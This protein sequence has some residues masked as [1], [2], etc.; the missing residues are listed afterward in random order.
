MIIVFYLFQL[1]VLNYLK[2]TISFICYSSTATLLFFKSLREGRPA[3]SKLIPG[4]LLLPFTKNHLSFHT[5]KCD[6]L[7]IKISSVLTNSKM[8]KNSHRWFKPS[9]S[10]SK[11]TKNHPCQRKHYR[12][13][14]LSVILLTELKLMN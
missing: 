5:S 13:V 1:F 11:L 12:N 14:R 6:Q 10:R 9:T 3:S 4:P 8:N 2:I 7:K